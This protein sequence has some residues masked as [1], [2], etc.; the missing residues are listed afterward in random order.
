V[1]TGRSLGVKLRRMNPFEAKCSALKALFECDQVS[2]TESQ[3]TRRFTCSNNRWGPSVVL[4]YTR[5]MQLP[6]ILGSERLDFETPYESDGWSEATGDFGGH[7]NLVI[8]VKE[9]A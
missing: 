9:G 4:T 5:M 8:V 2:M 3:G 7:T 1:W 6:A